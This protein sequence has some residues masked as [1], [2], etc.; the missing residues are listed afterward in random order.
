[1]RAM[2][3]VKVTRPGAV[4]RRFEPFF[5][6]F[7]F[8]GGLFGASPVNWMRRMTD[9]MDRACARFFPAVPEKEFWAPT[10][11]VTEKEG[12]Y[13]ATLELPGLKKEEV[14][15]EVNEEG[16]IISG[17]RKLEK[18]EKEEEYFRSERSYGSFY[19]LIPLPKGAKIEAVKAE[20]TN[21]VLMVT[22]PVPETK[23]TVKQIPVAEGKK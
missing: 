12:N 7:P 6:G 20:L 21:G 19:R 2:S 4:A 3:E 22:V 23:V 11:E 15:V 9:E 1:M 18:E 10:L 13:I 17:E 5:P 16:L 8:A 14:K